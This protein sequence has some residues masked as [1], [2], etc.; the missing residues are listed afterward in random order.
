MLFR[1]K[2]LNLYGDLDLASVVGCGIDRLSE[3]QRE[4]VS[5]MV[6]DKTIDHYQ[7][8]KNYFEKIANIGAKREEIKMY[9]EKEFFNQ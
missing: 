5:N 8:N 2:I 1:D 4:K 3:D 7:K 9:C 6:V